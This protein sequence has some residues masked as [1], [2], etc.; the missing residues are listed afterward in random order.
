MRA[1]IG[2]RESNRKERRSMLLPIVVGYFKMQ[3][4]KQINIFRNS[5]GQPIWHRNY[6]EHIICND[7]EFESISDYIEFN[8]SNWETKDEYY[9]INHIH[10]INTV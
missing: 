7:K 2:D 4:A 9:L 1:P 10:K 8:P 6:Y 3:S 5:A